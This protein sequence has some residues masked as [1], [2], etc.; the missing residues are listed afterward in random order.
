MGRRTYS[1]YSEERREKLKRAVSENRRNKKIQAVEYKGGRCRV[2]KYNRCMDALQFHHL[3]PAEK[4]FNINRAGT[5]AWPKLVKELD[6][7]VLL[8][9]RC[10]TE[11]HAEVLDLREYLT[12][13]EIEKAARAT[14]D[15]GPN[16]LEFFKPIPG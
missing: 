2:C 5:W 3:D 12:T 11:V 6:K 13:E 8:C 16:I 7:C 9:N 4:D 15:N 14:E 1:S 10:H